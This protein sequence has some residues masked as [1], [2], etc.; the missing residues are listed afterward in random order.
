V[1]GPEL[2]LK[3]RVFVSRPLKRTLKKFLK[4]KKCEVMKIYNFR[5]LREKEESPM[6]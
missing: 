3:D 4:A 1:V 6:L 5:G 2:D